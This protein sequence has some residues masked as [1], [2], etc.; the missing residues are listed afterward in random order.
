MRGSYAHVFSIRGIKRTRQV[1]SAR[2]MPGGFLSPKILTFRQRATLYFRVS[3]TSSPANNAVNG[4]RS[5]KQRFLCRSVARL[6]RQ[7][8]IV[9]AKSP[10]EQLGRAEM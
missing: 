1:T 2:T 8:A 3:G 4:R 7:R 5:G 9:P 6:L 10:C